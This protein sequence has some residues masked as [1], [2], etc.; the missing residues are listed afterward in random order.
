MSAEPPPDLLRALFDA[1]R[2]ASV[3]DVAG[4]ASVRAK[5]T[6]SV[7]TA[8]P[9]AGSAARN[10]IT[11]VKVIAAV[12][13]VIGAGI[14]ATRS[15]HVARREAVVPTPAPHVTA[16]A[17]EPAQTTEPDNVQAPSFAAASKAPSDLPELSRRAPAKGSHAKQA[18]LSPPSETHDPTQAELLNAAWV[19][20]SNHN[21]DNALALV[22]KDASSH[23]RGA[24]VEERI[25]IQIEAL[26]ELHRETEA[27]AQFARFVSLYPASVHRARLA[28]AVGTK[29]AL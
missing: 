1:E 9:G 25:A 2:S 28:R 12:A 19:A 5:I 17:I 13:L 23:P 8:L 29:E 22:E 10:A 27:G 4:K 24:L 16:R 6:A 18:T 15:G 20:L 7:G 21:P 14:V 11:T 3:A 26:A